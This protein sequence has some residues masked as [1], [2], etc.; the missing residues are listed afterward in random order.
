MPKLIVLVGPP[1]SGKSTKAKELEAQG[2][3]R[4]SQD[5]QGKQQ[6][7]DLFNKARYEGKDIV[8]DR[9]NF[10][11]QQRNRYL[12]PK[13]EGYETEIIVFHESYE[14]C[15]TRCVERKEHPTVKTKED[16]EK[17]LHFFFSH[18]SRV[19]DY[20]ADVVTRLYPEGRKPSAIICDLDG[21][22]CNIDHRLKWMKTEKKHWPQFF[23]GIKDDSVNNW[24]ESI[25]RYM[26][27]EH[28]RVLCSGRGMEYE[29]P[30]RDWLAKHNIV[31][32]RL[33]MRQAGD[34]RK[35]DVVKEILLD[36]EILTRYE[37][38]FMID[39]RQQVVDMWRKRG[40]VCLQCAPGQF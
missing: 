17:A 12:L 11:H 9:M 19:E 33:F 1:G 14:T 23:L 38:Y 34:F 39:D 32:D 7:M 8:V 3:F 40:F 21:T 15:L 16:A 13:E 22:L 18:Y 31:Y 2:Y 20:E 5:D 6:H 27:R 30:T 28:V 10:D 36:F 26:A 29:K 4:I 35:D 37:P 24:C 25:L